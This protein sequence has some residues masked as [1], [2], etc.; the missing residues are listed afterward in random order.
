MGQ[1]V[2]TF[3][4]TFMQRE[5]LF[6]E[7]EDQIQSLKEDMGDAAC[8]PDNGHD[9]VS[10]SRRELKCMHMLWGFAHWYLITGGYL[11]SL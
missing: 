8:Y 10:W 4:P 6:I 9:E 2:E 5:S 1:R 11:R 7:K 3:L